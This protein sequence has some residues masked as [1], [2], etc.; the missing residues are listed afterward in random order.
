M[1]HCTLTRVFQQICGSRLFVLFATSPT[2]LESALSQW[3]HSPRGVPFTQNTTEDSSKHKKSKI[4][5]QTLWMPT[6]NYNRAAYGETN[7]TEAWS[8][9]SPQ[10]K[11]RCKNV[12]KM[13]TRL[14]HRGTGFCWSSVQDGTSQNSSAPLRLRYQWKG[15]Q[16]FK[17]KSFLFYWT[18]FPI[19]L[20]QSSRERWTH[21]MCIKNCAVLT[22]KIAVVWLA[23]GR[24]KAPALSA[25]QLL[26]HLQAARQLH[27]CVLNYRYRLPVL[28]S[29]CQNPEMKTTAY[30][31]TLKKDRG[32][33]SLILSEGGMYEKHKS[34]LNPTQPTVW[35]KMA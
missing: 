17:A 15:C 21:Q 28:R 20:H 8:T 31:Q 22:R 35:H 30:E 32:R 34:F 16:S 25:T 10:L 7:K 23:S 13:R 24:A 6:H 1:F 2:N 19:E 33:R 29:S 5:R 14:A 12:H 26:W 18:R 9:W 4:E 27:L 11:M 3:T